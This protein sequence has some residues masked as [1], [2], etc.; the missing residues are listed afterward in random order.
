MNKGDK[1]TAHKYLTQTTISCE[2]DIFSDYCI[3]YKTVQNGL[4]DLNE[5]KGVVVALRVS[6]NTD[7][8]LNRML[9]VWAMLGFMALLAG[10]TVYVVLTASDIKW[11]AWIFMFLF[12]GLIFYIGSVTAS[13]RGHSVQNMMVAGRTMPLWIAMF[14]MTAT[15]VGGGYIAGT[16]EMTYAWGLVWAQAPWGY[17]LSLIIGGI[18]YARIMR[19]YEFMTMLDP[20]EVRYGQ[21]VAGILYLPALLGELFWSGAI[22]TALGTTFGLILGLD[23]TTSIIV[24]AIIAIAYT[25]VGGMWSV[26]LT[27]VAQLVILI[28]GLFLVLPF[29]F[30]HIGGLNAAWSVYK[31]GMAS[32]ASLFPPLTGWTDPE[33]G[34]WFWNWWDFA[35][36]LIFG[37]IPWQVYF[38]RVLSAKNENTAMWLSITAGFLCIIAAVPAVMIGVAGFGADWS[39]LGISEP[40]NPSMILAYVMYYMTPEVVAVIALGAVAAAVMSSMDSSILSASSMAAWNIY[41]PLFK[42]RASGKELKKV[43]RRSIITVGV[44]ATLIA[45]NV[46]S[47]YV[48]WYLCADLVYCILFPQLTTALFDKKANTYGAVA[49]LI[50]SFVLRIGGGEPVLGIPTLIP[51][52]MIVDGEVLF[53]FRTLA[54]VAGLVTIMVVSRLTQK[55]CPPRPLQKLKT[56]VNV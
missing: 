54:M 27:D 23:F 2:F 6:E 38:Q 19:R 52:P 33:W 32:A 14:T 45:L 37:G 53:P 21:K 5:F 29:A 22:L 40:E 44:A 43:I 24:S 8:N 18:F 3:M 41:R 17:G 48:L 50:V 11:G 10:V 39:A 36:L 20:L 7:T 35:L 9:H 16:A 28:V 42:P 26:A 15:W 13:K 30:S 4:N 46:E 34:P 31:E 56:K 55:Q 1:N 49:G 51:Y 12:Y 25:I 47:V